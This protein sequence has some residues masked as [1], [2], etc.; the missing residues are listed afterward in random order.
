MKE[1]IWDD[2]GLPEGIWSSFICVP[3]SSRMEFDQGLSMAKE[4]RKIVGI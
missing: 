2:I 1:K 4:E 3:E